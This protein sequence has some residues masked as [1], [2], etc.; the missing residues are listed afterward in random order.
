MEQ[1]ITSEV[2]GVI[3]GFGQFWPFC[4]LPVLAALA[5]AVAL[6]RS[7]VADVPWYKKGAVAWGFMVVLSGGVAA[8]VGVSH[9]LSAQGSAKEIVTAASRG[10]LALCPHVCVPTEDGG[11]RQ[12]EFS[13]VEAD[14][15][16]ILPP[17]E[18]EQQ[19]RQIAINRETASRIVAILDG[20]GLRVIRP[21]A[22]APE[23]PKGS[24]KPGEPKK[25]GAGRAV[26]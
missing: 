6:M 1:Q 24:D 20:Y 19:T 14:T 8:Y 13:F 22:E 25:G 9:Y 10:E 15:F 17:V 23:P 7:R 5:C 21:G 12:V 2:T 4:V 16:I 11:W 3:F 18:G 26:V